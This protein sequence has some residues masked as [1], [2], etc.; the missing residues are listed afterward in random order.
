M[1][2][3]KLLYFP[4]LSPTYNLNSTVFVFLQVCD[5]LISLYTFYKVI[6][7]HN[8]AEM[9]VFQKEGEGKR[10]HHSWRSINFAA[11]LAVLSRFF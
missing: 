10:K 2:K 7:I 6:Y 1:T 5:A 9:T 8:I 3:T 4:R 11:L